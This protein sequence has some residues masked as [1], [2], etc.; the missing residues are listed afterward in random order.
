MRITSFSCVGYTSIKKVSLEFSPLNCEGKI[1]VSGL[2][3]NLFSV[4]FQAQ[5]FPLICHYSRTLLI[6]KFFY[7]KEKVLNSE[8]ENY[9]VV[10]KLGAIHRIQCYF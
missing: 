5:S 6:Q 8:Y 3:G 10:Q 9:Q 2:K 7:D 4:I 1:N